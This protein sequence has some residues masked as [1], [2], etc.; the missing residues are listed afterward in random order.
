[1]GMIRAE[2][3]D[4]RVSLLRRGAGSD[5]GLTVVPGAWAVLATRWASIKPRMGR[6]PVQA[7]TRAGEA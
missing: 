4:R 5:D 3:L 7:G 1:M 2:R 6:E